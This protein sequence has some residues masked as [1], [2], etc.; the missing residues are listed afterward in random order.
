MLK[1]DLSLEGKALPA[2]LIISLS[3]NFLRSF[4]D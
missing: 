3:E 2:K 4:G 1:N